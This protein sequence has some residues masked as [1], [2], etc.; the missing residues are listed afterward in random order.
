MQFLLETTDVKIE[1]SLLFYRYKCSEIELV[2]V[3]NLVKSFFVSFQSELDPDHF[4]IH[5]AVS[6]EMGFTFA[7]LNGEKGDVFPDE[8]D[9]DGHGKVD[10]GNDNVDREEDDDV[11]AKEVE[12]EE[13]D[14]E[15]EDN[16]VSNQMENEKV[17][18]KGKCEAKAYE[19][20]QED[21][22]REGEKTLV[23]GISAGIIEVDRKE[24]I[25][26][27]VEARSDLNSNKRPEGPLDCA[28]TPSKKS[29]GI[30]L[31]L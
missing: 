14:E 23:S 21:Q 13:E 17:A 25:A 20:E 5:R 18:V 10:E 27:D 16:E 29:K 7:D 9:D 2:T 1:A 31:L 26:S 3:M 15:E 19:D 24:V 28:S 22:I 6:T 12:E 30:A 11:S 8:E 4:N